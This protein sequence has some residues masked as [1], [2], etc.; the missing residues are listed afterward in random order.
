[1]NRLIHSSV[2][3]VIMNLKNIK[4]SVFF[5]R[6]DD[7]TIRFRIL[8]LHQCQLVLDLQNIQI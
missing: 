7:I 5:F 1:M 4:Q 3:Y 2:T 6:K 8:L